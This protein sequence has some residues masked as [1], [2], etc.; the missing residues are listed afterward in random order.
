MRE[1]KEKWRH[2]EQD[3]ED[4]SDYE[5]CEC[6]EHQQRIGSLAY[7]IVNGCLCSYVN[8]Q[9]DKNQLCECITLNQ[10]NGNGSH[11]CKLYT[12]RPGLLQ[13]SKN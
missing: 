2:C 12:P 11:G 5:R 10:H 8:E 1:G 13:I 7:T 3:E 9:K 6:A 4:V